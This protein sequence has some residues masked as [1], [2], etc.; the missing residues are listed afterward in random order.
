[1]C[2]LPASKQCWPYLY[3]FFFQPPYSANLCLVS[4]VDSVWIK[5]VKRTAWACASLP[6]GVVR[7]LDA[8]G[9]DDVEG[10]DGVRGAV[11]HLRLATDAT[12]HRRQHTRVIDMICVPLHWKMEAVGVSNY[13]LNWWAM[14]NQHHTYLHFACTTHYL[15]TWW[16]QH[17]NHQQIESIHFV[18]IHIWEQSTN[19]VGISWDIIYLQSKPF[20]QTRPGAVF[21]IQKP[22]TKTQNT[23]PAT[24]QVIRTHV[25]DETKLMP[26]DVIIWMMSY[27]TRDQRQP[28]R[29][30]DRYNPC[31]L[32][33]L[34]FQAW[35]V[36]N[37]ANERDV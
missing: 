15:S 32:H 25:S 23:K 28:M 27:I 13:N 33:S 1:M 11:V 3:M 22:N 31:L 9:R 10:Q 2:L 14:S 34:G 20:P 36:D 35:L 16:L 7:W 37:Q 6:V 4:C 21:C 24:K 12:C 8:L 26:G 5:K 18:M 30:S 29:R 19:R 17:I